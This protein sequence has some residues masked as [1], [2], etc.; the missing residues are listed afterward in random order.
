M[1]G[2]A[3]GVWPQVWMEQYLAGD[4]VELLD[5]VGVQRVP[6]GYPIG[7]FGPVSRAP[8]EHFLHWNR[9]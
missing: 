7:R 1:V 5:H 6:I 8:V 4:V 2:R 9:W 3:F